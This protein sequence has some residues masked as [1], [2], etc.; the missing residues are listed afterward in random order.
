MTFAYF[1]WIAHHADQRGE[2]TAL[3][4]T[5][6][7]RQLNYAELDD[8]VDR[9]AARFAALGARS[10]DRI[11]VLAQNTTDTLEVQFAAFRIGAIFVPL[12][13][14]LT[15]YE[16][17]YIVG[18]A[19]PLI[20]LHDADLTPMALDLRSRCGTAHTIAYGA[21][22]EVAIAASPRLLQREMMMIDDVA[23]IMYT[24]GTTGRP[25]GAMITHLMT[26]IN[27]I[28][29]GLPALISHKSVSLCVLPLFHTGGLNCYTNPVL[30]AGGTVI[31]MRAFDAG[32][33]LR[34]IG[35][36]AVGVTHLF[37]VPSNYQFMAQHPA[38]AETDVSRLEIAG[39]G[40]APTPVTLLKTWL[41][42]GCTLARATA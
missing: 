7:G 3:I 16:L 22:Y 21:G 23:T 14:R 38:F 27:A 30:H 39:V 28:N 35:E 4:D 1:D 34:L 2:H 41:D 18:D 15:I 32:E 19:A 10:G 36:P 26:F 40:G 17:E 29:V 37:G 42:R 5:A 31:V 33:A 25:K 12:N 9:L 6:S 20:L 11:A 13:V 8:R 24:S